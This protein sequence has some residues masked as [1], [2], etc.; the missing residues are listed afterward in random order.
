MLSAFSLR[1]RFVQLGEHSKTQNTIVALSEHISE[2]MDREKSMPTKEQAEEMKEEY[3]DKNKELKASQMTQERLQE[4]L[5]RRQTDLEKID[6][7]DARIGQELITLADTML[8]M[9]VC[10]RVCVSVC[11]CVRV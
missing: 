5:Q 8:T 10:V 1:A 7:L 4:E 2:G 3:T 9:R 6:T 11:A